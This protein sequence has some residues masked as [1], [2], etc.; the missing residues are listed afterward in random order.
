MKREGSEHRENEMKRTAIGLAT[1]LFVWGSLASAGELVPAVGTSSMPTS[2]GDQSS[3]Q[4]QVQQSAIQNATALVPTSFQQVSPW[5]TKYFYA[6][7][8]IYGVASASFRDLNG[9]APW[10]ATVRGKNIQLEKARVK[11][12]E[13]AQ[14]LIES[15]EGARSQ[16]AFYCN[17]GVLEPATWSEDVSLDSYQITYNIQASARFQCL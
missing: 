10:F 5:A 13:I 9:Q 16:A 6:G 4:I 3:L 7:S 17:S 2:K 11:G 14:A 8:R 1:L 15:R 12:N